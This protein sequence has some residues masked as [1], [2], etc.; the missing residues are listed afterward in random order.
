MGGDKAVKNWFERHPKI[1]LISLVLVVLVVMAFAAEKILAFRNQPYPSYINRYAA[2]RH[3]RLRE[4]QPNTGLYLFPQ[5]VGIRDLL[6]KDRY[7]LRIDKDGF[8]MP[9]QVHAKPD[10]V[11]VFL[12]GSTTACLF[13]EE[14]NR[15][16]YVAGRLLEQDTGLKVNALNAGR[17]A[18]N[19][20]N[21]INNLWNNAMRFKPD[22]A[23]MMHNNNDLVVLMYEKSYWNTHKYRSPIEEVKP[24]IIRNLEDSVHLFRDLTIPNLYWG[25]KGLFKSFK[26]PPDE[27]ANVRGKKTVID[28]PFLEREYRKNLLTFINICRA[29]GVEPVLMTMASRFKEKSDPVLAEQM[30]QHWEPQQVRFEDFKAVFD[31]FNQINRELG[32]EN[33]VKVI[34]LAAKVPQEKEYIYDT[35][36]YNDQGSRLAGRIISAEIKPILMARKKPPDKSVA[37]LPPGAGSPGAA[38]GS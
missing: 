36:H 32:A 6:Q 2:K 35:M 18:N 22:V 3:I 11:V 38:P 30:R 7:L 29:Q 10:A 19:S 20:L 15:F 16:P 4:Y 33:G 12:G 24:S 13:V 23:V 9:S 25:I 26:P 1:T 31:R 8:I 21:S 5:S 37:P 14:E 34:D 27:F 17:S 28:P